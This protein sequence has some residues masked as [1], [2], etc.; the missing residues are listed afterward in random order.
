MNNMNENQE[1]QDRMELCEI[2]LQ[3]QDDIANGRVD[4]AW[5]MIET[6]EKKYGVGDAIDD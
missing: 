6:L 1:L 3:S 5:K 2:L 4:D